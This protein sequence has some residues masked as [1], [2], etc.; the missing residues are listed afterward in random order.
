MMARYAPNGT[1]SAPAATTIAVHHGGLGTTAAR[2]EAQRMNAIAPTTSAR[3]SGGARQ[4]ITA[5]SAFSAN[6]PPTSTVASTQR[7]R[8]GPRQIHHSTPRSAPAASCASF[9]MLRCISQ[10]AA[11]S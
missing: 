1:G 7:G 2:I 10:S 4:I 5:A 8:G 6:D 9:E 11:A 3:I